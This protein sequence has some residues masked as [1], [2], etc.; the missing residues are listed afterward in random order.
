[1]KIVPLINWS[2]NFLLREIERTISLKALSE[3]LK[4]RRSGATETFV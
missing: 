2:E 3:S 4:A 1:M